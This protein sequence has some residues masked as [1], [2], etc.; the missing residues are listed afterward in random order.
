MAS[1]FNN[2][3]RCAACGDTGQI[4]LICGRDHGAVSTPCATCNRVPAGA[5]KRFAIEMMVALVIVGCAVLGMR[6]VSP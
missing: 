5:W 3:Q 1:R 2:K 6:L 4:W